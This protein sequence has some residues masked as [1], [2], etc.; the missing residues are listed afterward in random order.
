MTARLSA[1][2]PADGAQTRVSVRL[3]GTLACG[4]PPE[5]W[6]PPQSLPNQKQGSSWG[7]RVGREDPQSVHAPTCTP[8]LKD[9]AEPSFLLVGPP[10][11][12]AAASALCPVPRCPTLSS[13]L[14]ASWNPDSRWVLASVQPQAAPPCAAHSSTPAPSGLWG[15]AAVPVACE[16]GDVLSCPQPSRSPFKLGGCSFIE[17]LVL[18][19]VLGGNPPR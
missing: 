12:L 1:H 6:R 18:I 14:C 17:G 9:P 10:G 2:F 15:Q 4:C 19:L 8:T 7:A 11:S 5:A 3:R 13:S 16:T